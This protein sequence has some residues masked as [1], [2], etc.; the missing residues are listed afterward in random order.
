[1]EVLK[2]KIKLTLVKSLG[3]KKINNIYIASK[4]PL[5]YKVQYKINI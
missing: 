4:Q 5:L 2:Y 1:M 3:S